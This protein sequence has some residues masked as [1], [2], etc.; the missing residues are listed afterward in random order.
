MENAHGPAFGS[1][2]KTIAFFFSEVLLLFQN[3]ARNHKQKHASEN[4]YHWIYYLQYWKTPSWFQ[5]HLL[6]YQVSSP[7]SYTCNRFNP[8]LHQLPDHVHCSLQ[9]KKKKFV[10]FILNKLNK[11][12]IALWHTCQMH[13]VKS[14]KEKRKKTSAGLL[15]TME[16]IT[17]QLVYILWRYN[18]FGKR[19][20]IYVCSRLK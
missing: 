10:Y 17:M 19:N 15:F 18:A 14:K 4:V 16:K 6:S 2:C 9:I 12:Y 11:I 8:V 7:V 13:R 20:C 1:Q 5:V 3:Y